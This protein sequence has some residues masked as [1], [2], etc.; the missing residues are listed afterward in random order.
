MPSAACEALGCGTA[1]SCRVCVEREGCGWSVVRH[2][3]VVAHPIATHTDAG[4]CQSDASPLSTSGEEVLERARGLMDP[5][6][7]AHG[8]DK[9]RAAFQVLESG[10]AGV[11]SDAKLRAQIDATLVELAT[12]LEA[13][14][15]DEDAQQLLDRSRHAELAAI[16]PDI[17]MVPRQTLD[18]AVRLLEIGE[19][20][21]ITDIFHG[22]I[23]SHP[24][25]YKWTLDYLHR[26]AFGGKSPSVHGAP[27]KGEPLLNVATD[28]RGACCRYYEP[29]RASLAA[30][31]PYPFQPRTHL[32][33]DTFGGFVET[34]RA[35]HI[36]PGVPEKGSQAVTATEAPPAEACGSQWK[37]A[38]APPVEASATLHY[39]HDVV[40]DSAGR[41]QVGGLPLTRT[42]IPNPSPNPNQNPPTGGRP[43]RP[44]CNRRGP[45]GD[46]RDAAACG[47]KATLLSPLCK[48][49]AVGWPERRRDAPPL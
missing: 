20:V 3:C 28:L 26:I 30:G 7:A 32:Y 31:Y 35:A 16:H 48:C 1:D 41:P 37:P 27:Q 33:R 42:L 17:P 24:V 9:L 13:V 4:A 19:P 46:D 49:Q 21:V 22:N 29:R 38:E 34:L 40:M 2:R 11:A 23:A 45:R 39:L 14:Y 12:K 43:P 10:A 47:E 18:E 6:R 5:T 44:A 15:D 8:A 36:L 25:P